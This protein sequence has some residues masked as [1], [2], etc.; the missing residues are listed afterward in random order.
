VP[1]TLA[2]HDRQDGSIAEKYAREVYINYFLPFFKRQG[3]SWMR[4]DPPGSRF[5]SDSGTRY[6]DVDPPEALDGFI[7]HL[8]HIALIRDIQRQ[9]EM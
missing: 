2:H 8:M 6:Q 4:E 1:R 9:C 7:H 5:L 3:F